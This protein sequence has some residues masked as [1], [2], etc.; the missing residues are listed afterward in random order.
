[1]EFALK[2]AELKNKKGNMKKIWHWIIG[3]I[4]LII[5]VI[6]L[7]LVFSN[8]GSGNIPISSPSNIPSPPALP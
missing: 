4:I 3:I 7:F 2:M 6:V 8:P 1:M 5:L